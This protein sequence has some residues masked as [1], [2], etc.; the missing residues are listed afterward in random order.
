MASSSSNNIS[1]NN[2]LNNGYWSIDLGD[3]PH[4]NIIGNNIVGNDRYC[5]HLASSYNTISANNITGH[6]LGLYLDYSSSNNTITENT[7]RNCSWSGISFMGS[8]FNRLYHNNFHSYVS[9]DEANFWDNGYPSGGN[10]WGYRGSYWA[11]LLYALLSFFL[12]FSNTRIAVTTGHILLPHECPLS[13]H[14]GETINIVNMR[15][16]KSSHIIKNGSKTIDT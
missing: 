6:E 13:A 1:G 12:V 7:I 3:S 8:N 10:Y 11:I 14:L 4:N 15:F 2:V 5:I 9:S 16:R